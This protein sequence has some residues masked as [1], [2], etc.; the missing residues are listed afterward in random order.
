MLS[1]S[2]DECLSGTSTL[3]GLSKGSFLKSWVPRLSPKKPQSNDSLCDSGFQDSL[4][5]SDSEAGNACTEV[6]ILEKEPSQPSLL[7]CALPLA[8]M[9]VIFGALGFGLIMMVNKEAVE[10]DHQLNGKYKS[11]QYARDRIQSSSNKEGGDDLEDYYFDEVLE[12]TDPK[13]RQGSQ[14]IVTEENDFDKSNNDDVTADADQ[15]GLIDYPDD[16]QFRT[17]FI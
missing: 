1:V 9:L 3:S 17:S 5:T 7:S 15:E 11:M 12:Y 14:E 16:P 10:V 2:D 4:M 8:A 13:F 6:T